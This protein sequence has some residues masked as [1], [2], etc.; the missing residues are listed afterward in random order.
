M[1]NAILSELI[2]LR[3]EKLWDIVSNKYTIELQPAA[4]NEYSCYTQGMNAI[5][6][7]PLD[8]ICI[9]SFTHELLHIYINCKEV[10]I[11]DLLSLSISIYPQLKQIISLP[12]IEHIGNCLNHIKMLPLYLEMGFKREEFILDYHTHK[13]EDYEIDLIQ[14]NWSTNTQAIDYYIGKFTA[15]KADA[16]NSFN[17][18]GSFNRLKEIDAILYNILETFVKEWQGFDIENHDPLSS[19]RD[20]VD[21]FYANLNA[22][23]TSRQ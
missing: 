3:N 11:S 22:W 6:Y 17:Y 9:S 23:F 12:L 20:I 16:N 18:S 14:S 21:T 4:N 19:Y 10:Y 15:I 8:K 5:I 1:D 2:D 7:I 13:C